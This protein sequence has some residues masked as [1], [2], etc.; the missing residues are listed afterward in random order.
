MT[1]N[2][3]PQTVLI[4]EDQADVAGFIVTL[5][6]TNGYASRHVT[7]AADAK[8]YLEREPAVAAVLLDIMMP[9]ASGLE[10]LAFARAHEPTR[11]LPIIL[12]TALDSEEDR[13]KGLKAGANDYITKPF[14]A[15]ELLRRMQNAVSQRQLQLDLQQ[16]VDDLAERNDRL[17]R[18]SRIKD[19][20]INA[21]SHDIRSPLT[22]IKGY[23]E[24][25][26]SGALGEINAEQENA[27]DVVLRNCDH[28]LGLLNKLMDVNL[29]DSGEFYLNLQSVDL[30]HA[31]MATV[32]S[33]KPR[34]AEKGIEIEKP[35]IEDGVGSIVGDQERLLSVVENLLG[36][37][38]KF[39]S[40]GDRITFE[41]RREGVEAV[42]RVADTGPGIPA[43][44]L[45]KIFSRF[46]HLSVRPTGGEKSV[47]LGLSLVKDIVEM[48]EGAIACESVEGEGTAFIV[49][50]PCAGPDKP[51]D[52]PTAVH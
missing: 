27:V 10:V 33:L 23:A 51:E 44:E 48:H 18:I 8:T 5:L 25:L 52:A 39:C 21:A 19:Q 20:F 15:E 13:L 14:G 12:V 17:D 4:V 40:G 11:E 43:A 9:D 16:H 45:P 46:S 6:E 3:S 29:I 41:L 34:A 28:V 32:V 42:L 36:N 50:L 38:I 35:R 2:D 7:R 37:A 47:G 26:K 31:I 30:A 24:L 49:R 22:N 1:Q